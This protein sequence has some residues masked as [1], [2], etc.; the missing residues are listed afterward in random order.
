MIKNR[1][2]SNVAFIN[3]L[4]YHFPITAIVSILHRLTGVVIFIA[5]P[6]VLWLL[7]LSLHSHN[8]FH[9]VELLLTMTW[10]R[11][12]LWIFLS[13]LF[14]HVIAG[15][16]HLLMD[17][18]FGETLPAAKYSSWAVIFIEILVAILLGVWLWPW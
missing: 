7:D 8:G 5:I 6:F 15:L 17:V 3:L 2:P 1:G 13:S 4:N 11:V 18:G 14:F 16:K 9:R 10:G 12:G